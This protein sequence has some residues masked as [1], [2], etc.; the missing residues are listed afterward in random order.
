VP[1]DEEFSY[2][3]KEAEWW[4]SSAAHRDAFAEHPERYAP[5]Y[6]DFCAYAASQE[7]MA[8]V[9]PTAWSIVDG[10][11]YLNNN[12]RIQNFWLREAGERIEKADAQR[13]ELQG[14]S[15]AR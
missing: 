1:G 14:G 9:D 13:P 15:E 7:Q 8:D 4:F 12:R 6:G 3:W 2:Q 10:R 11:L 5:Q